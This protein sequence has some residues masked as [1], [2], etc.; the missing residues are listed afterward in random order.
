MTA[1]S[2]KIINPLQVLGEEGDRQIAKNGDVISDPV[3]LSQRIREIRR[4]RKAIEKE[5]SGKIEKDC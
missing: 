1:Q 5:N 2:I 3:K 4:I